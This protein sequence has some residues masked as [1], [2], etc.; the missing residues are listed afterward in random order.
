MLSTDLMNTAAAV[1]ALLKARGET[2]GVAESSTGGLISAALLSVPG[3]SAYYAGGTVIYTL[4][5]A[6]AMLSEAPALPENVT[7]ASEPFA[8]WLASAAAA[9]L[10]T[11]WGVGETGTAGPT[12]NMYGVPS[13]RSWVAVRCPDGE[14]LTRP[15]ET[16]S[17][18][19]AAN[20]ALFAATALALLGEA[21]G[22]A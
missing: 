8:R 11:A 9:T 13:G 10:Q 6:Q 3:A 4:V 17:P 14:V 22:G 2:I 1:A 19:R 12:G 15:I 20:M 18:D 7:G 5:G 16:E 21:L